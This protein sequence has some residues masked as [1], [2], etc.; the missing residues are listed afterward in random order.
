MNTAFARRRK[1]RR[2]KAEINVVP[3]IDVMLV[4]LVIFM[5]TAPLL[6]L[7]FEVDL[8]ASTAPPI[9]SQKSPTIVT[10]LADGRLSLSLPEAEVPKLMDASVLQQYLAALAIQNPDI[11]VI[12]AADRAARYEHVIAGMDVIRAAGIYKVGMPTQSLPAAHAR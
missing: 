8:P 1:S 3:Y 6:T 11:R 2:L 10:V 7:S 9:E 4:L 12:V 5:V